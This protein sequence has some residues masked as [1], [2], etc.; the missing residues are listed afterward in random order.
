MVGPPAIRRQQRTRIPAILDS[1]PSARRRCI[2]GAVGLQ[3]GAGFLVPLNQIPNNL[4]IIGGT[5]IALLV[6]LLGLLWREH[7]K[8]GL[9]E[10]SRAEIR[11]QLQTV[12]AT[13]REAVI[14]YDLDHRLKF[15]NPAFERLTGYPF[16]DL[17]DQDFLNYIHPEDRPA[18]L[19]E[20]DRLVQGGALRDQEYRIVTRLGQTR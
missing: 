18:I 13:M 12:T 16:E 7:R 14:A 19:G 20:W 5:S 4:L 6:L 1:S 10:R 11:S 17:Q 8:R 15:I 2:F 3:P 9:A